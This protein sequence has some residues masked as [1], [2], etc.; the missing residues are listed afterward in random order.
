MSRRTYKKGGTDNAPTLE[1][2]PT[3]PTL[4]YFGNPD[5]TSQQHVLAIVNKLREFVKYAKNEANDSD[6][7]KKALEPVELLNGKKGSSCGFSN[8]CK[9]EKK[10]Q[11]EKAKELVVEIKK[12][13]DEFLN[14]PNDPINNTNDP[15]LKQNI[16]D[17]YR[18]F[19]EKLKKYGI[20]PTIPIE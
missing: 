17:I 18:E 10:K 1:K 14:D 2:P 4:D 11:Y 19:N 16:K 15:M 13:L 12:K 9:N 5:W 6:G 3:P 8:V 20:T 7:W